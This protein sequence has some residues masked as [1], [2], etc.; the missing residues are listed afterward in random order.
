S[1]YRTLSPPDT[2][3]APS[4]GALRIWR[5]EVVDEPYGSTKLS[6][7]I[8]DSRRLAPER[9]S[10]QGFGPWMG[11]T[12]PRGPHAIDAPHRSSALRIWR[13]EVV[14]EPSRVRQIRLE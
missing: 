1:L 7:T 14:D 4:W 5:R 8:L 3:S 12:I 11:Q 13:R 9:V 2:Q 10:A 6:G